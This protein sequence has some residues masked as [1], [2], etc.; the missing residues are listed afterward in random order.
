MQKLIRE[1]YRR[2]KHN[3]ALFKIVVFV[4]LL[5]FFGSISAHTM[6]LPAADDLPRQIKIGETILQGNFEIL[7]KNVYSYTEPDQTF[8]NHH[9]LS[10]VIFYI[11]HSVV[12]WSGLVVFKVILLLITFAL[13]FFTALKKANFWVVALFSIPAIFLLGSRTGLRPEIFSYFFVA[14]YLYLLVDLDKHP[15]RNRVFL[16]V[17]M[18]LLWVNMHV[19]FSIGIMM[20]AGFLAEKVILKRKNLR[21]TPIVKKLAVLLLALLAIS[22]INPRGAEGV[23]YRY[24]G[25]GFPVSI[26]ENQKILDFLKYEAI[27][28]NIQVVIFMILAPLLVLSFIL[29][30]R[31]GRRPIFYLLG[32]A[33]TAVLGF[34]IIRSMALFGMIFLPAISANLNESFIWIRNALKRES[35]R[36][37]HVLMRGG[38][39]GLILLVS[40]LIFPG[41]K[42]LSKFKEFGFGPA[43]HSEASAKFFKEQRLKGPILNDADFGSYLIYYLYPQERVFMD[44][45][46]ADAYSVSFVRD[47]ASPMLTDEDRWQET[48]AAY[49]FNVIFAYHYDAAPNHRQFLWRRMQDPSW[50]LVYADPFAVI[51]VKNVPENQKVIDK[52]HITQENA[53]ERLKYLSES[54]RF[55]EQVSAA[56]LFNLI[57]RDDLAKAEFLDVVT[58]WPEKG[59]IWMILGQMALGYNDETSVVLARMFLERAIAEGYKTAEAYSFLG[60]AYQKMNQTEKAEET[61]RKSLKINPERQDAKELLDILEELESS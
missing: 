35:P 4:L 6:S 42:T 38:V 54:P 29:G 24:P 1:G 56:D 53:R 39:I 41:W 31:H 36:M 10:G 23:L 45:R 16:L 7:Y 32:S 48:L 5:G 15:E 37:A 33:A 21:G 58:Q 20:T 18:Q 11:L 2:M 19:F 61:L 46:F 8:Y 30:C 52:F 14:L 22:F 60:A 12:G 26:S 44:N 17:P 25:E 51:L 59:K 3:P 34:M 47:V 55:N 49:K 40:F 50:A 28:D 57:G 9:W 13:L 27:E 43:P